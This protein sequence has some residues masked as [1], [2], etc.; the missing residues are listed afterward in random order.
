MLQTHTS[1]FLAPA[2]ML[3]GLNG[4]AQQPQRADLDFRAVVQPG[5]TIGSHTFT[6]DTTIDAAAL[7]DAGEVAFVAHW[8]DAGTDH[9]AVFTSTRIVA[10][11]GDVIDGKFIAFLPNNAPVAINSSGQI[12]YEAGY[13]DSE[14]D[15][16]AGFWHVGIFVAQHLAFTLAFQ[17]IGKVPDFTLTDDGQV[18]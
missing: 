2:V 1:F 4:F 12:A 15:A 3:A 10:S 9:A 5:M 17:A 16:R 13:A 18:V 14:A 7:N 6:P 11:E 8:T